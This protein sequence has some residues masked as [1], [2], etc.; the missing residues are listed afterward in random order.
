MFLIINPEKLNFGLEI[1][2]V[3]WSREEEKKYSYSVIG[4]YC[5]P[6]TAGTVKSFLSLAMNIKIFSALG[7]VA[8]KGSG[9]VSWQTTEHEPAVFLGVQEGQ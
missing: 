7:R 2:L 5:K 4:L 1:L 3:T 9:G 8:G 6:D